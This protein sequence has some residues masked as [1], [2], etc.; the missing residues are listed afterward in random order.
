LLGE[1]GK[2]GASWPIPDERRRVIRVTDADAPGPTELEQLAREI[3]D[4]N[5]YLTLGTADA[6]GRPW[7]SPVYYA[8]AGY[9]EFFWVS[10]PGARHSRNLAVRP[11]LGIVIFDSRVPIGSG[12]AL[13]MEASAAELE[14]EGLERGLEV[15][16]EGSRRHG[17]SAWMP[18][19]VRAPARHRLYRAVASEQFVLG[20]HDERLPVSL[21]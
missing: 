3:V 10:A 17:G 20:P 14:D 8:A 18:D 7:A 16:S 2:R 9:R 12:Q 4:S 19:D 6:Q 1:P 13:Y 11:E 21:D 15:F 5:L